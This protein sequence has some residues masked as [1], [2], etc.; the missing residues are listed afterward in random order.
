MSSSPPSTAAPSTGPPP[1]NAQVSFAQQIANSG[2]VDLYIGHHA[3]VPQPIEL[4]PGGPNGDGRCV[5]YGLG[6]C[7][8][9]QDSAFGLPADTNSGAL[10]IATFTVELDGT[11]ETDVEWAAITVD[12]R[13]NH[14]MY[15]LSEIPNGAGTLSAT[16]VAARHA[17]V[18]NAVGSDAPER[19]TP[20]DRLADSAYWIRRKPWEPE[21]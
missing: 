13:S 1:T 18:K 12:R 8:S 3:H 21:D 5:A 20:P 17:R 11:V 15:V 10:L 9:N 16:E 4:L 7:I 14:T 19:L 2:P 6:N